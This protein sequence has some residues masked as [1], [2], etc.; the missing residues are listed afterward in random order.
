MKGCCFLVCWLF[1]VRCDMLLACCECVCRGVQG[2]LFS[3]CWVGCLGFACVV[4]GVVCS[5]YVW[6]FR[7]VN[8]LVGGGLLCLLE[9]FRFY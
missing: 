9:A 4:R 3:L 8:W 6:L 2:I 7:F 5:M 1:G